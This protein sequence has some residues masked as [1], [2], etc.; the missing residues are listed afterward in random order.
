[1]GDD[2]CC[3]CCCHYQHLSGSRGLC[4][5]IVPQAL[6]LAA[7]AQ[8]RADAATDV[9][10]WR[11]NIYYCDG[12]WA[13]GPYHRNESE[14]LRDIKFIRASRTDVPALC[15]AVMGLCKELESWRKDC[16]TKLQAQADF[17]QATFEI[18]LETVEEC[19]KIGDAFECGA[20]IRALAT[21]KPDA[22]SP[23]TPRPRDTWSEDDGDV[24]WW[25][26]PICEPPYVGTP[27]DEDFPEGMTHWTVLEPPIGHETMG[28]PDAGGKVE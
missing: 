14:T 23:R 27:L 12:S 18:R 4:D 19:A 21:P 28:Q 22:V 13:T 25:A 16:V 6:A 24:I 26:I 10:L 2:R 8:A 7:S 15:A 1:M 3:E 17:D 9:E 5:K 20:V 11:V